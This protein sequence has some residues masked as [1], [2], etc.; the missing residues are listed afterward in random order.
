MRRHDLCQ[1]PVSRFIIVGHHAFRVGFPVRCS[2]SL[3]WVMFA[4]STREDMPDALNFLF[5]SS[6]LGTCHVFVGSSCCARHV[7]LTLHFS[8]LT[9]SYLAMACPAKRV[10]EPSAT[11]TT[12]IGRFFADNLSW[13][14]PLL[15]NYHVLYAHEIFALRM[16]VSTIYGENMSNDSYRLGFSGV[17]PAT[18]LQLHL[19]STSYT[20]NTRLL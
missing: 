20:K 7:E 10:C 9:F 14:G 2:T 3:F 6:C 16:C 15:L 8:Y 11:G 19:A 4:L 12:R 5:N 1:I 13:L 18:G 17:L